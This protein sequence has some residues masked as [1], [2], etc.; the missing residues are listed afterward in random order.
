MIKNLKKHPMAQCHVKVES[1]L[2]RLFSYSTA[3]VYCAKAR[4][5]EDV[6]VIRCDNTYS[7]STRKHIGWFLEEYF[8]QLT[9]SQIKKIAED[10]SYILVKGD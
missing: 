6:W 4:T 2:I 5:E 3:V 10:K 7:A 9:Y 8:P 1:D